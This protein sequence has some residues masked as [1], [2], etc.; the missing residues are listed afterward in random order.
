MRVLLLA[1]L[2]LGCSGNERHTPLG[3]VSTPVDAPGPKAAVIREVVFEGTCD[4][5][6][7]VPLSEDRFVVADDEDNVLRVYDA[8]AGGPPLSRTDLSASLGLPL[9]GKT[10]RKAPELDLEAATRIGSRAYWLTSHARSKSGKLKPERLHLF[11]TSTLRDDDTIEL[12]GEPYDRLI[13]DLI[14]A[15]QLARFGLAAAAGKA[16]TDEGGLNIEGLTAAPDGHVIIAFRSPVPDGKALLV[17]LL[18][19]ED[20]VAGADPARF[21]EPVL[22]DLGDRGVRSMSW[23]HGDYLLIAGDRTHRVPSALF[24]W[25][26]RGQPVA[27]TSIDLSGYNPEA[28]FTPEVRDEI[29]V[30]SDDGERVVHGERC[31]DLDDPARKE[32]RGVWLVL[33]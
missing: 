8:E 29:L 1:V 16:P 25:D 24:T 3:Y 33:P 11:A 9:K 32:F 4:A 27:V 13:E 30:L 22:L 10:K 18:N 26:G 31:K 7:A 2:L 28:F 15:P 20:L 14:D 21:G 19:I 12:I 17:P 23:W 6:G 5:S